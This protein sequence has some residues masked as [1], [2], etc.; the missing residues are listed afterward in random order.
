MSRH[1]KKQEMYLPEWM[2]GWVD[3]GTNRQMDDIRE[4]DNHSTQQNVNGSI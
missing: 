2:G 4:W 3:E 1:M